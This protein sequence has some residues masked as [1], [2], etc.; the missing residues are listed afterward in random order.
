MDQRKEMCQGQFY[1]QLLPS[2]FDGLRRREIITERGQS[3][4][5]RLPKYW[6]TMPTPL[7]A[8]RVW[9]PRLCWGGGHM[10]SPGRE[11]GGGSIF[12]KTR[13]IGLPSYSN[14]LSTV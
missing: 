1:L 14:N 5:Y 6:P 4:A 3:Y 8:R 13:D 12:W 10:H 2:S 7:S 9:N 11:G